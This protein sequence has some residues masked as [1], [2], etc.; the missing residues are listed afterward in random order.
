MAII[1]IK[2]GTAAEWNAANP[3]LALA[4]LGL[5]T[6]TNKMKAG[7]GVTAWSALTYLAGEADGG[8]GAV[9]SVNGRI[10]QVVL[11]KTDVGLG[12]VDNTSDLGKPISTATQTALDA[13]A[14]AADVT[15]LDGRVTTNETNIA[16]NASDISTLQ[17]A[18]GGNTGDITA[19][20]GR[21]TTNEGNISTNVSDISALQTTSSGNTGDITA[22]DGRVTANEGNISTNTGN[23]ATNTAD[24]ATNTGNIATNTTDIATNTG[25]IGAKISELS[26]DDT[27]QLGGDL[28]LLSFTLTSST[29]EVTTDKDIQPVNN[30]TQDLGAD[31]NRWKD[32][33]VK[34]GVDFTDKRNGADA[35]LSIRDGQI[36]LTNSTDEVT[37]AIDLGGTTPDP[38]HFRNVELDGTGRYT[39]GPSTLLNTNGLITREFINTPGQFFVINDID[40]GSFTG[41][42]RQCFG[43]VRE[44]MVDGSDFSGVAG[45][46]GT[47][48]GGG[49]SGGWSLGG[50]WYYTGGYPYIWTTYSVISQTP[51]G[52][53]EGY[54]G[55]F[56]SQTN[57]K[58]W[59]EACTLVGVGKKLRVG[60][61]DGTNSDVTG[62]NLSNR[63][64]QQLWVPQEVIDDAAALALLP[65]AVATY[66]EGWYTAW[67]TTGDYENM[68]QFPDS[69]LG[70]GA[71]RQAGVDKGYRFRWSTFGNTTLN[72]LPYL[73]GVPSVNDQIAAATGLSYYLVY[74]P[75]AADK[76]AANVILATGTTAAENPF[77]VSK[78]VA[79][80]QFQ[81]PYTTFETAAA[82][83]FE[84]NHTDVGAVQSSPLFITYP[85]T[86]A[87]EILEAGLSV[88]GIESIRAMVSEIVL[89]AVIGY[90]MVRQLDST[91]RATVRSQFATI[92]NAANTGQ[93][94][95]VYDLVSQITADPLYP[96]ELLDA[97]LERT[98]FYL[99]NYPVF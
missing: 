70:Y 77:Y 32:I 66:G 10:G 7:D 4:E 72:Q 1:Q 39:V 91:D 3:I 90:Y 76:A 65:A 25:N 22:L 19:L 20:E 83:I 92:M 99:K 95:E 79:L 52:A 94:Q 56:S 44:T 78:E 37:T 67:G 24:I 5:E 21:V 17:T 69:G 16:T 23:I 14:T 85:L 58:K 35:I 75:T 29:A 64:V 45:T 50:A 33:Y 27:P 48:M 55:T 28:D 63:L 73:Q 59:W 15:A 57:Q 61:A 46:S 53:G 82:N 74:E 34:D 49:N 47:L 41:G 40:G 6:D 36:I 12:V 11:D 31:I 86:S 13:K 97:L 38:G 2:R 84:I 98:S 30:G 51:T 60:I 26:E 87:Q 81:Q 80:L 18:S 9:E 88:Q 42:N 93:L 43:L 89:Q 68:G 71:S 62:L 8:G 54:L 96:Q